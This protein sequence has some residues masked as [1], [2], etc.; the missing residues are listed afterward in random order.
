MQPH[1][2]R[3]HQPRRCNAA[4]QITNNYV[5]TARAQMIQDIM[6]NKAKL[7]DCNAVCTFVFPDYLVLAKFLCDKGASS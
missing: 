2:T 5:L 7:P 1:Q 4:T 3:A 6:H